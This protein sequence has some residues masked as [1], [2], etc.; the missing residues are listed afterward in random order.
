LI[1][2]IRRVVAPRPVEVWYEP[3]RS[4]EVHATWC[5]IAKARRNLGFDPVTQLAEGL[6]RTWRWFLDSTA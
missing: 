1:E 2:E 5:D 4:G 6:A 3:A